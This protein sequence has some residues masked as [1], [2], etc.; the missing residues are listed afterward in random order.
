MVEIMNSSFI[1][2]K[3][4][5]QVADKNRGGSGINI[6]FLLALIIFL[7]TGLMWAGAFF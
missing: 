5:R 4:I 7:M 1:P 2:K 6:F 3:E